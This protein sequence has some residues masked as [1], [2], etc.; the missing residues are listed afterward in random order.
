MFEIDIATQIG[1]REPMHR[2][3]SHQFFESLRSACHHTAR[4]TNCAAQSQATDKAQ[5]A[6]KAECDAPSYTA[7]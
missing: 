5:A 1:R 4:Q 2:P 3:S 6:A 7:N